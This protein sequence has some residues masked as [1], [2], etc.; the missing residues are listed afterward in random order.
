MEISPSTQMSQMAL[1]DQV[2]ASVARKG[3]DT[4]RQAGQDT[5]LLIE[6]ASAAFTNPSLGKNLDLK[7]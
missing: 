6:A 2:N 4:Q 5:L 1:F 3:L 7:I